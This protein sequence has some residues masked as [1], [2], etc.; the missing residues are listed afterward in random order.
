MVVLEGML[1]YGSEV[2]TD[3]LH[4]LVLVWEAVLNDGSVSADFAVSI[5]VYLKTKQQLWNAVTRESI[6]SKPT[7]TNACI[8]VRH[9]ACYVHRTDD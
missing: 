7:N 9:R 5:L 1:I 4:C 3:L 8:H 6:G 2:C